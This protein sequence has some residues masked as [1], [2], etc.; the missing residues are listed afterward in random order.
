MAVA[1]AELHQLGLQRQAAAAARIRQLDS[2]WLCG[3]LR[4]NVCNWQLNLSEDRVDEAEE[5][6][7]DNEATIAALEE[8]VREL[9]GTIE[10]LAKGTAGSAC[11]RV[12]ARAAREDARR[13]L[14]VWES[15]LRLQLLRDQLRE[16]AYTTVAAVGLQQL[17]A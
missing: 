2:A 10:V 14:R 3:L 9:G 12:L 4:Q 15:N 5:M 16:Q 6:I 8:M 11:V 17:A 1:D 7:E 13:L